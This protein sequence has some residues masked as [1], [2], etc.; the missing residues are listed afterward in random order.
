MIGF[1]KLYYP[2][3]QLTIRNVCVEALSIDRF[4]PLIIYHRDVQ[5]VDERVT[6]LIILFCSFNFNYKNY[7]EML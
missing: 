4:D 3:K 7:Y 5:E 2:T 1:L 6:L